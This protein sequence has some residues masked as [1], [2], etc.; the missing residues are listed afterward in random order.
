MTATN[1]IGYGLQPGRGNRDQTGRRDLLAE[2]GS[3]FG[4]QFGECLVE[5]FV[6]MSWRIEGKPRL[7]KPNGDGVVLSFRRS[8]HMTTAVVPTDITV[9]CWADM[10]QLVYD[11][12]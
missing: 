6:K 10:P 1:G 3:M 12:G 8:V 2:N 9:E 11:G 5:E 7:G 4:D